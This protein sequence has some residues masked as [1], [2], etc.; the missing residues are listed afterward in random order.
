MARDS[1]I[2]A[3]DGDKTTRDGAGSARDSGEKPCDS[4]NSAR[5]T[6]PFNR[7]NRMP[8]KRRAVK[9]TS[10]AAALTT[11]RFSRDEQLSIE[12]SRPS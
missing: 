5:R 10:A 11:R 2:A 1:D 9:A 3:R 12:W 6:V 8:L 7:W 4:G